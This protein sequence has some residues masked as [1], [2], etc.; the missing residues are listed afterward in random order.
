MARVI[1]HRGNIDGPSKMENAPSHIDTA[2]NAGFDVEIDV[3]GV[4]GKLLLGHDE[5]KYSIRE[6]SLSEILSVAWLHCKN[7]ESILTIQEKFPNANYFWHQS[8]DF[9]FTS[10]G[11]IWTYPGKELTSK[12]VLVLPELQEERF[13]KYDPYGVCTDYPFNYKKLF[14]KAL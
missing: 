14:E 8:D 11:Y 13:T 6:R 10:K 1:A 7:L 12:S 9:T 2:V 5:P 3:W 4:N